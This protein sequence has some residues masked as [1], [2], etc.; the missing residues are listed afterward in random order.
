MLFL[1]IVSFF[2][3]TG[4]VHATEAPP[5]C[6][7]KGFYFL[8]SYSK[9]KKLRNGSIKKTLERGI[10]SSHW[11]PK[12][13]P[14]FEKIYLSCSGK[15]AK[16]CRRAIGH[17]GL[18]VSSYKSPQYSKLKVEMSERGVIS[19][20]TKKMQFTSFFPSRVRENTEIIFY[21]ND[22]AKP[23]CQHAVKIVE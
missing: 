2:I 22:G 20:K 18:T 7:Q 13:D 17:L 12:R 1:L 15:A 21:V 4:S 14:L 8:G 9:V 3:S 5:P 10:I 23:L 6:S 16:I 19:F 11:S